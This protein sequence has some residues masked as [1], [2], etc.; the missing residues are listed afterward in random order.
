MAL[1]CMSL[2]DCN[3]YRRTI[4]YERREIIGLPARALTGCPLRVLELLASLA[5][6]GG[7]VVATPVADVACD[8]E[9]R[10]LLRRTT[11]F[12]FVCRVQ[13]LELCG[14]A[15]NGVFAGEVVRNRMLF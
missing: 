15:L 3:Q 12:I 8:N 14:K 7:P 2:I 4:K 1:Q 11:T 13:A 9:E 10:K 6:V 5:L